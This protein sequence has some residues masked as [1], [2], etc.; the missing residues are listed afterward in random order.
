MM[1]KVCIFCGNKPKSKNKEHILPQW[2]IRLTGDPSRKV[3]L[4][5]DW[6]SSEL[7][8]RVYS[9]KAFTFPACEACNS[10]Y[11]ELEGRAKAVILRMLS[12]KEVSSADLDTLLDWLDKVR[13]GLWIGL[14]FLNKNYR[15]LTPQFHI[16][17]RV[18]AKDRVLVIYRDFNELDGIAI[19]G[20]ESPIFQVMPS[21]FGLMINH[22]HFFSASFNDLLAPRFGFPYATNRKLGRHREGFQADIVEGTGRISMPLVPFH[23][24]PGGVQIYQPM[25]P[26]DVRGAADM[27]F[28]KA[29]YVIENCRNYADGRGHIFLARGETL[30]RYPDEPSMAWLP[31]RQLT[32][33]QSLANVTFMSGEWLEKLYSDIPD[34]SDLTPEQVDFIKTST[35]GILKLH[36]LMMEHVTR[37]IREATT[38]ERFKPD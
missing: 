37:Q 32:K 28:W 3:Y 11:S 36:A 14:L 33:L 8:K 26:A 29:G 10:E 21:C 23:I 17:S 16:K 15:D 24:P 35:Q 5:R 9:F 2:L 6:T 30:T 4:G 1:L 38:V 20:V 34:T 25:I 22:L 7:T 31:P 19:T 27:G 13:I 18:A 12:L